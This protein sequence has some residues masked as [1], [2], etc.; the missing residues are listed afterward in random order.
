[1]SAFAHAEH[2]ALA[3]TPYFVPDDNLLSVMRLAV[4]RGV[5]LTLVLPRRSNHRL[6]DFVRARALRSLAAAGADI[7]L[8]DDMVHAKAVVIDESLALCGSVNLDA[9]SL[10]LNY[11]S[12]FLFY[13]EEEVRWLSRWI[14]HLAQRGAQYQPDAPSLARDVAEGLML[15]VAFQL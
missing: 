7:R 6:A 1:M 14:E 13:G 12:E 9:R 2:R 15:T 4:M 11:E 3:V 10:L 5:R 8:V